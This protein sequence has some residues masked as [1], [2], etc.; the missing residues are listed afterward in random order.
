MTLK[1]YLRITDPV[2]RRRVGQLLRNDPDVVLVTDTEE[3][4]LVVDDAAP[5]RAVDSA[6]LSEAGAQLTARER[7]VLRHMADGLGNKAIAVALGISSHTVKYH[8]A[9]VLAKL[10]VQSRTEAVSRGLREGLLPL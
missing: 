5:I 7:E 1:I 9:S 3:A 8:V 6:T 4:D 2:V 10:D